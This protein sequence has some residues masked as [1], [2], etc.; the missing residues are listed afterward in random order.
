[1]SLSFHVHVQCRTVGHNN[2]QVTSGRC[3]KYHKQKLTI[4]LNRQE[5]FNCVNM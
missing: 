5:I 3:N 1:M 4:I 2:L